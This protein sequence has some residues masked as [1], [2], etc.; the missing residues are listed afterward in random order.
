MIEG[1]IENILDA[2]K[3][4]N[5]IKSDADSRGTKLLEAAKEEAFQ[6][7]EESIQKGK[8]ERKSLLSDAKK[9]A[10]TF[11]DNSIEEAKK[12]A[13]QL[14]KD[15]KGKIEELAQDLVGRIINGNC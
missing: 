3:K 15:N 9:E 2:E 13:S 6:I 12:E 8:E 14:K 10:D 1:V 11:F 4:A 7:K 5:E